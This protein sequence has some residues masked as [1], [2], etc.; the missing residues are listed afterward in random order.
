M[1]RWIDRYW[2][3]HGFGPTVREIGEGLSTPYSTIYS[4]MLN[5]RKQRML[6]WEPR[7]YRTARVP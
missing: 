4:R 6:E 1:A 2:K 3:E 7:K 5:M